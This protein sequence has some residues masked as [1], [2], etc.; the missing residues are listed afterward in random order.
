MSPGKLNHI[1][2]RYGGRGEFDT[3]KDDDDDIASYSSFSEADSEITNPPTKGEMITGVVIEMDD[4]G[5]LLEIGGK[6]SGYLPLKEASLIPI[7]HVNTVMNVGDSITAEVIGTLKGMPV[8]SL[9]AAQLIGAWED[10]LNTRAND[11]SFD[12]KVVEINKGGAI[13]DAFGLKAFLPGSH[14][15]GIPDESLI[16]N[17][18][19]VKFLD[20]IEEEGKIVISQRKAK[21]DSQTCDLVKY[22]VVS[23]TV[24]GLRN[25]GVFLEF[26]GGMSGLLHISQISYDRVDNLEE[27]FSIGQTVKVMIIDHDKVNNR[28]ALSTKTL[29]P[30]PGDMLRDMESVFKQAEETAK[31]YVERMDQ[32]RKARE[33]T[34]KDIVAGLGG[35]MDN[36]D[37]DPLVSVADSIESI[38]ASI[39]SDSP[40]A[41]AAEETAATES[42]SEAEEK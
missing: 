8:I 16:G 36:A 4:N 37:S 23:G 33:E 18:M 34:A 12:V 13:C 42:A 31:K 32:E 21:A 27:V 6:M 19:T 1:K 40:D 26:E 28:V 38:L 39:V 5:A 29:E 17:T 2:E 25:Y 9:R 30:N 14:I 41:E 22:E 11:E 24:T 10:I 15:L 20:V 7:K 3:I 35:A